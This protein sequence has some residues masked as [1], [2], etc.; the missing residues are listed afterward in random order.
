MEFESTPVY[1]KD[2]KKLDRHEKAELK[3]ILEKIL[4]TPDIGKPMEHYANVF[5]KRTAHRRLIY[6]VLPN[7][8]QIFAKICLHWNYRNS[9]TTKNTASALQKQGRSI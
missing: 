9:N 7:E 4:Q 1:D 6:K 2:I 3:D 8:R 5:S